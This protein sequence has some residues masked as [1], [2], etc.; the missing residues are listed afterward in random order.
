MFLAVTCKNFEKHQQEN[1]F[2]GHRI[3]VASRPLA[4][5]RVQCDSCGRTYSYDPQ[6]VLPFSGF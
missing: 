1:P 4:T 3:K 5:F 6:D 2:A